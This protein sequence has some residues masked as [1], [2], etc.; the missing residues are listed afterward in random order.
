MC[1]LYQPKSKVPSALEV[2][3]I[4]GL[5]PGAHEGQGLGNA[6]LANIS[7]VDGIYHVVRAFEDKDVTH[8][9]VCHFVDVT[10]SNR[11]KLVPPEIWT[12]SP[13]NYVLR[14]LKL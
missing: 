5:V 6:F 12:L 7:A 4:A 9:E 3:D 10:E 14:I 13:L 2:V 11:V 1:D 8:T